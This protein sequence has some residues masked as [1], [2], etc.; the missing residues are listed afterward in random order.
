MT[1]PVFDLAPSGTATGEIV[2]VVCPD[3]GFADGLPKALCG[4]HPV[5]QLPDGR[6]PNECVVCVDLEFTHHATCVSV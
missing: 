6:Y 2:H 1:A 5:N 4:A 3:C